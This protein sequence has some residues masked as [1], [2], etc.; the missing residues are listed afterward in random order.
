MRAGRVD[1]DLVAER[2][3]ELGLLQ[4]AEQLPERACQIF[5]V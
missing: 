3:R 5:R 4:T 1:L 2:C